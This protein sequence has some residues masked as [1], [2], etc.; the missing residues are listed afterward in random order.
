VLG[1]HPR[2]LQPQDGRLVDGHT[3]VDRTRGGCSANGDREAQDRSGLVHHPD[4]VVRYTFLPC[5][6]RPEEEGLVPSRGRV[7]SAYDNTLAESFVVTLKTK[8]LYRSNPPT[9]QVVRPAIFEHIERFHYTRRS[10]STF[11]A[12]KLSEF[13]DFRLR[14]KDAA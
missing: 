5:G 13:E 6:K 9:Q 2:C 12:F 1:L 14:G 8:L 11:G 4:N 3:P 10:H 7:G